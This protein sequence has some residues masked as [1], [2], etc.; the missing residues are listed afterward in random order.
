MM[1]W[2]LIIVTECWLKHAPYIPTI[3]G[4][5]TARTHNNLTQNEGV[6]VFFKNGLRVTVCEPNL[7]DANCLVLKVDFNTV[8]IAI[9]RPSGYKDVDAFIHSLNDL[10]TGFNHQNI[11]I[12]GDINIDI[13]PNTCDSNSPTYLNMLASH[14]ILPAHLFPTHNKTCLDHVMMT[15][16]EYPAFCYVAETSITDHK[17]V[18]FVLELQSHRSP[19]ATSIKKIDYDTLDADMKNVDLNPILETTDANTATT[20]LINKLNNLIE[21]NT[22]SL[23]IPNRKRIKKPWITLGVLRCM[24]N[25]A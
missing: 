2:D 12:I 7:H 25:R 14:G 23:K 11:V 10:L 19:K 15:K 4:Y 21:S 13:T 22:K 3:D 6:V 5:D 16:T 1:D 18:I 17:A 9:Y 20:L 24:K 8:V